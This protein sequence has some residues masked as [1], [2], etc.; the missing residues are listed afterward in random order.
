MNFLTPEILQMF[1]SLGLDLAYLLL[2]ATMSVLVLLPMIRFAIGK[3]V[4]LGDVLFVRDN[5]VAGLEIGG[6]LLL[7]FYQSRCML[8]GDAV[9][10]AFA[11]DMIATVIGIAASVAVMAVAR[12]ALGRFVHGH[13]KGQDLNHEIFEQRNWA[14]ACV[15]LALC[16]GVVNGITEEDVLGMTP[17]RDGAIAL[18]VLALG[19]GATQLYRITHM[20]GAHFMRTFFSDDNPAAG[21]SLLGFAVAANMVTHAAA[22]VAK[23]GSWNAAPAVLVTIG[24]ATCMLGLLVLIRYGVEVTL[25]RVWGHDIADE[26]FSQKNVG[27]GFIDAAVMIGSALIVTV[28]MA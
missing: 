8:Q 25:K 13:N 12:A 7:V 19:L 14:A 16:V 17:M 21:V 4:R 28:S 2:A 18:T 11:S 26:I 10:N 24:Y 22:G 27:A 15:S 3:N 6:M 20:R 1:V 9:G 23:A 5:P